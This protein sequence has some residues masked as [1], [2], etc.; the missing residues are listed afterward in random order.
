MTAENR[1]MIAAVNDRGYNTANT[2]RETF[3]FS[4]A[5]SR[6]PN[7]SGVRDLAFVAP[8]SIALPTIVAARELVGETLSNQD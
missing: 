7:A 8:Q 3:S 2:F 1:S 5:S 6:T 4:F